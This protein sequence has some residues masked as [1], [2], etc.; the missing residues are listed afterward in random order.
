[1]PSTLLVHMLLPSAVREYSWNVLIKVTMALLRMTDI[2]SDHC[3]LDPRLH[4]KP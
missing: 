2:R 1:M 4:A 3:A